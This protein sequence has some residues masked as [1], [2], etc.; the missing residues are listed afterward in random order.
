MPAGVGEGVWQRQCGSEVRERADE[1]A[2]VCQWQQCPT[3]QKG[4]RRQQPR[5]FTEESCC[6]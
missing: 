5:H 6:Q 1:A 4:R 3:G 2:L